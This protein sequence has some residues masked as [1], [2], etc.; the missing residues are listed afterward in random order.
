MS[1]KSI[2]LKLVLFKDFL[3]DFEFLRN[4]YKS[5]KKHRNRLKLMKV[6]LDFKATASVIKIE[7]KDRKAAS[8]SLCG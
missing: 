6:L 1:L 5:I 4:K 2:S 3:Y 8:G 7:S